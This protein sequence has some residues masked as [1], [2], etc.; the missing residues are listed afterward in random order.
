MD[1]VHKPI[2]ILIA[3]HCRYLQSTTPEDG[4]TVLKLYVVLCIPVC[5]I[6]EIF[7]IAIDHCTTYR[8]SYF[9]AAAEH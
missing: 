5:S 2:T 8:N 1:K 3:L 7:R 6:H 9:V 4:V